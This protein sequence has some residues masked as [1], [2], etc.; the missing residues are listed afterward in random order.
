[1]FK[2]RQSGDITAQKKS[3]DSAGDFLESNIVL[4]YNFLFNLTS[5]TLYI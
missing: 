1:M 4:F 2:F 3:P 5:L